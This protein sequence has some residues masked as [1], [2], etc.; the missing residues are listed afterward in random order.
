MPM[1]LLL[2]T[3]AVL[4]PALAVAVS[5]VTVAATFWWERRRS[6]TRADSPTHEVGIEHVPRRTRIRRP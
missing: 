4:M 2:I 1:T 5:Y 6:A 3:L